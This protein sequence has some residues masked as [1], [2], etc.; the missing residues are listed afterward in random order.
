MKALGLSPAAEV[1][2]VRIWRHS[3]EHWGPDQAD[4][5]TNEIREA[6]EDL[7]AGVRRGRPVDVR[8]GYLKCATGAHM[9]YFRDHADG[10]E[11][12]RILHQRQDVSRN[13]P[14]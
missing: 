1:D 14:A 4:R 8:Q 5:Y 13:L 3:A 10:M 9:I 6:C 2:L 12:V 7:A 11:V